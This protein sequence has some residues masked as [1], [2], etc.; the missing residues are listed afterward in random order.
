MARRLT[1]GR[2]LLMGIS[3]ARNSRGL[4]GASEPRMRETD[5][6][7]FPSFGE[8]YLSSILFDISGKN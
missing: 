7:G 6:G 1:R 5:R 8:R 3:W 4:G 2:A